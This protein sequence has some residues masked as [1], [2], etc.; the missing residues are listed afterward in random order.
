MITSDWWICHIDNM[1][2]VKIM[3]WKRHFCCFNDKHMFWVCWKYVSVSQSILDDDEN[4]DVK[5]KEVMCLHKAYAT[6]RV[7][8]SNCSMSCICYTSV[9]H[10]QFRIFFLLNIHELQLDRIWNSMRKT[11]QKFLNSVQ[12]FHMI[13]SYATQKQSQM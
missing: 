10:K 4:V 12:A 3:S 7:T 5:K 2:V 1:S 11:S 13:M 9:S 6:H 8:W